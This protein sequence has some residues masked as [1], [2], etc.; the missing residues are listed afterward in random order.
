MQRHARLIA[1]SAVFLFV[2]ATIWQIT[3]A[4]NADSDPA[5]PAV[6]KV[7]TETLGGADRYLT[8][9]STDK[10]IYRAGETIYMRGV[11]LHHASHRPLP[12]GAEVP[13]LVEIAGPKGDTVASGFVSS[14]DSVLGY[15][16]PVPDGQAGGEYTIRVSYPAHGFTPAERKFDIRAYRA[17]RLKSQI[18]FLRDGYG[19]GDAVVGLLEVERAEGGAPAD[20]KVTVIA[21]VDGAVAYQGQ[22][23]VDDEG[24]CEARFKLPEKIARGEGTLSM[25]IEDGGIVETASKTIPILL[26]T[27]DLT[28]YPEGGDLVAGLPNRVYF[29]AFTPAKKPADLAGVVLDADGKEVAAF[30]SEHEGRG[31][32]EFTPTAGAKYTLKITEPAGINT[33]YPLPDVQSTGAVIQSGKPMFKA[34]QWV[35]F[36][37][38]AVGRDR[39][40]VTLSK[41]EREIVRREVAVKATKLRSFGIRS[42]DLNGTDDAE[43]ADGV[44]IATVWST[45]GKPLAERLIYRQPAEKINV[46]ITADAPRYV[47]GGTAKLNIKTT[48]ADGKPIAAVVGVTVTDDSVLEMIEKR[49][50]A[51]RLPVMVL[52]E[53]D[54]REL[55]DAHVY[56][57]PKNPDAPR[58]VDLLLGTQ[59]WRRF[60]LVDTAKWLADN[61]DSAR[62]ALA[63]RMISVQEALLLGEGAGFGGG[64]NV[65]A[66]DEFRRDKGAVFVPQLAPARGAAEAKHDAPADAAAPPPAAEP[67]AARADDAKKAAEKAPDQAA[68]PQL[69]LPAADSISALKLRVASKEEADLQRAL[70]QA[71]DGRRKRQLFADRADDFERVAIR[72]DFAMVRVYAHQVRTGRQP[73]ERVDF[74]ETLYWSAGVKTDDKTGTATVE[75]GL[76]DAVSS[77]RVFA[78]AFSAS[79]ALGSGS[80]VV[81][82]VEPFYVEPKLPLEVTSGDKIVLPLGLVN[83]TDATLADVQLSAQAH[84]ALG[85]ETSAIKPFAIDADARVRRLLGITVGQHNGEANFDLTATAGG[86]ADKVSRTL[87]VCPQGFPVEEGFGGIIGPGA[88]VRHTVSIPEQVV[89][90]SLA[91]RVVV[92][93]TPLANMTEA[94][95]RLIRE[96]SGC[97]EQTSSTVYPLVMAQQYFM[98]HQGVDPALVEKSEK[99]LERGAQ[100]LMGFECKTGGFE[101]FG[102]DPG[103]EALTAYGLL[104]FTDMSQVRHVDPKLLDRT[105]DWLL[106]QRDGKGGF[107]RGR[108]TLHTWITEP[109]CSNGYITWAL[110]EAG[111]P[112]DQLKPEIAWVRD[113][114]E[115]TLNT[116]AVALSANVLG[117]AGDLEGLN[118][119][120]DKLSGKQTPD[121]SLEGAT[122]SIVGSGGE[123]LSIETTALA[124]LA[125]LKNPRYV[126]NVELAMKYLAETCKA[127]RFGS[128]QS[129]VLALR[130]IVAYDQSRAKPKSPGYLQLTVDGQ[131]V[132]S[133][134]EFSTET[135]GAIVLPAITELLS[136]G[137]HEV[138]LRMTGGSTMPYSLALNYN[139]RTPNSARDCKLYL[140]CKLRDA[141]LDEGA[142]TEAHVVV[143][144]RTGETVPN[145]VAII[146]IP[147]GLEVRHDQLKELVKAERIAAYEVIGR[148]V[149]LYW[150]ALEAEQRVELPISLTAAIPGSYTGPASRAYLYYTDEDKQWVDGLAVEIVPRAE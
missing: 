58:D 77:F 125:W 34:D 131:A 71:S 11:L 26:Q 104:E 43:A 118:H 65:N 8:H 109:E 24:R 148:E 92:Y 42:S 10:P 49:E 122:T 3:W 31:R 76:N 41:R 115:R 135:Q 67:A 136:A 100:R 2:A 39:V 142:V 13:A 110:L 20:A 7:T 23:T 102:Q 146:G 98:S 51:P 88:N 143:I 90:H 119:L 82:S 44:L 64:V 56:L 138:E 63:M 6:T 40:V 28:M 54:V 107:N 4:E 78:D 120:L 22:T 5:K 68:K 84:T 86:F 111:L 101:W 75:F 14:Q 72:N 126:G 106:A 1:V 81:E 89:P 55:A 52:L 123:A 137:D 32:F 132:G 18:K 69:E 57:D 60:A 94:L 30:R 36:R 150:R 141:K 133:P 91:S 128:T 121:G 127:G 87:V 124:A 105:R 108:R 144:N 95:E 62:R 99:I 48:G 59:G 103:H 140:E 16:W 134:V 116:Y 33:A 74:T 149:V 73:G 66:I 139:T 97:F 45:D 53:N 80:E 130:A 114:G 129:T 147:G 19:P 47:P 96:P 112:P 83:A 113:A 145:P 15:S 79:G 46:K 21:R 25:V 27:V 35:H 117:L 9:L 61:G 85:I 38:G 70:E 12:A 93:P 29:E 37:L 50:Q 17:P